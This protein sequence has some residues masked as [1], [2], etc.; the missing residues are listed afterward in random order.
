VRLNY[1]GKN[2]YIGVLKSKSDASTVAKLAQTLKDT[3]NDK[4]P[5]PSPGQVEKNVCYMR[6]VCHD[7]LQQLDDRTMFSNETGGDKAG[8]QETRKKLKSKTRDLPYGISL[9]RA[10]KFVSVLLM[11]LLF[12]LDTILINSLTSLAIHL[13]CAGSQSEFCWIT[14]LHRHL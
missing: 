2:Y 5:C 9:S 13:H 10:G 3:F 7:K 11:L 14:T 1:A 6:Q 12:K 8:A 4:N